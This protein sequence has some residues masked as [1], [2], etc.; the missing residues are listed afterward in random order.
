M[1][2]GPYQNCERH[3]A[4]SRK[5]INESYQTRSQRRQKRQMKRCLCGGS[6]C[7]MSGCVYQHAVSS[8]AP[9]QR[10]LSA[11]VPHQM[12]QSAD[13]LSKTPQNFQTNTPATHT[14]LVHRL[15]EKTSWP[16]TVKVYRVQSVTHFKDHLRQPHTHGNVPSG[17][18]RL[19]CADGCRSHRNDLTWMWWNPAGPEILVL[20]KPETTHINQR[21]EP[22]SNKLWMPAS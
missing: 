8:S 15:K 19:W 18:H 3:W 4:I 11:E 7:F 6:F 20:W 17:S 5:I 12:L 2:C 1:S 14:H 13:S 10:L 9:L 22:W 16:D 21:I